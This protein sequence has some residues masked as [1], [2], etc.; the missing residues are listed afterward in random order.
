MDIAEKAG[1]TLAQ[2]GSLMYFD[3]SG[4]P[5]DTQVKSM[6]YR[7]AWEYFDVASDYSRK[8][9]VDKNRSAGDFYR[10]LVE[11]DQELDNNDMKYFMTCA[12]HMLVTYSACDLDKL[13]LKYMWAEDELPVGLIVK[14]GY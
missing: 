13:S 12:L 11:E 5:I 4:Q 2:Y 1:A 3:N 10:G 14:K 9:D 7:K 6:I 8:N